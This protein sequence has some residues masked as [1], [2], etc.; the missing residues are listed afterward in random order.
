MSSLWMASDHLVYVKGSGFLM[1]FTEEYKRF[2]FDEIQCLSVVRTS[3][4]GKGVLYGGGLVF[5]SMLV[6]LIFG[7]NAGEGITVGVAIL[8]SLFG[9]LA[10]GCLALLLRH[11]ILGPSCLC[12]IQTSLSRE[13][14][15]PLNRLHQTS[16]AVAQI[17]GLI[18][19]AQ[20]SIEKAAPSEKGETDDLPS[21]QSATA[22]AKAHVADAFRVPALVLPSSLAFIVLGVISLTALHI[23]NVVLAGVVMLLLLAACFLVIMS[24]VGAV[25]HATPPPVK[26]S[27]WTQLGLLFFV[28]GSGAIYY[29]TAATMNPS[30][31]LG[32]LGPLEAFSAIGT[33]GGVWFYFWFLFLGLS[34]FSVGLAGAI[35]SMKWKKQLA[36]VEERKSSSVAPSEEGDG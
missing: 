3:R 25:R 23:E 24:L 29:L 33:D 14:L 12:D 15:R 21:K 8:V 7:V 6:A 30:Y 4:V 10:L 13:R 34:V 5:A 31:T 17:E 28:I 27:L 9:L 18:R 26:V 1:P 36:Q 2:R 20:I 16:Q 35:Q 19:E 22:K 11:L 32:I